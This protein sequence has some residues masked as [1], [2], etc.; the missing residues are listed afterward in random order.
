MGSPGSI[1][2]LESFVKTYRRILVYGA[3]GGGDAAGAVH[4]YS[5]VK[6]LGGEPLLAALVWERYPVDPYPGP[7]PIESLIDADFIGWSLARVRGSTRALRPGREVWPQIARVADAL[8]IEAYAVDASKGA[9]GVLEA[10]RTA[11][12]ELGVEAIV[13]VDVGGDILAVGCEEGLWSPLADAMSLNALALVEAPALLAVQGPGADG[14]LEPET[15]LRYVAEI[16]SQEG[17]IGIYG[18]ER[19]DL[20]LVEKALEASLSEASRIPLRA[21]R[22][23]WGEAAIRGGTRRVRLTPLQAVTFLLD[24]QVAYRRSPMARAVEGTRGVNRAREELNKLC[25][26]TELDLELDLSRALEA[27]IQQ[28]DPLSLREEGRKRL[29]RLGCTP[30]PCP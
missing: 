24:P 20:P 5:K 27:G 17:L 6:R 1:D 16:A 9:V 28:P 18:L 23:E 30:L 25:I 26:Y 19:A 21:F 13:G 10:L 7:I 22:G 14:E 11:I 8:G 3:G 15:V 2:S 12:E 4:L 29:R